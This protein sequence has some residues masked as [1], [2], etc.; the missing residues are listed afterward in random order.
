MKKN[1]IEINGVTFDY[2]K[3]LRDKHV[4]YWNLNECYRNP[5]LKKQCAFE[6][7]HRWFVEVSENPFSECFGIYAYTCQYFSLIMQ[8]HHKS[9]IYRCWLTGRHNYIEEVY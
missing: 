7:W 2:R 3:G 8:F 5:S 1:T 9:H 4:H 6:A